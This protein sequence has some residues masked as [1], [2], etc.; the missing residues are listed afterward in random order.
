M[1]TITNICI[2]ILLAFTIFACSDNTAVQVRYQVEKEMHQAEKSLEQSRS[3]GTKFTDKMINELLPLYESVFSKAMT[4]L[5]EIN[6]EINPVEHN[7]LTYLAYQAA[8][9]IGQLYFALE[10]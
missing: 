9:R 6:I 4:G 3:L 2:V 5:K 10:N 1:K 8:N 7:E